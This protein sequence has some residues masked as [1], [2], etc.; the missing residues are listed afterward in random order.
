MTNRSK[1][2]FIASAIAL[3]MGIA[4]LDFYITRVQST[5]AQTVSDQVLSDI[6]K[7]NVALRSAEANQ[8]SERVQLIWTLIDKVA[9]EELGK[10]SESRA[11]GVNPAIATRLQTG[12]TGDKL[13]WS[14]NV[15]LYDIPQTENVYLGRYEYFYW[16]TSAISTLRVFQR[17]RDRWQVSGRMEQTDFVRTIEPEH[18]AALQKGLQEKASSARNVQPD[19]MQENAE[20]LVANPIESTHIAVSRT[21]IQKSDAGARFI[22]IHSTRGRIAAQTAVQWLWQPQTSLRAV[23]WILGDRWQYDSNSNQDTARW[24][25]QSYLEKSAQLKD[26]LR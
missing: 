11:V 12:N 8:R 9:L 10:R 3:T 6:T 19:Y 1:L 7:A 18:R 17:D 21:S 15:V 13:G 23:A 16:T 14:V 4:Y 5:R 22:T 26:L 2:L 20:A 24:E 25:G